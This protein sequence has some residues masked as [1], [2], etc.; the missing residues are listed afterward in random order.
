MNKITRQ[1]RDP[2]QIPHLAKFLTDHFVMKKF[3]LRITIERYTAR[4][5]LEQNAK[6]H[7]MVGDIAEHTGDSVA[8][9]KSD[10][11][12]YL[13]PE[14]ESKVTGK[15]RPK[16]THELSTPEFMD[17]IEATYA[18]GAQLNVEWSE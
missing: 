6:W 7:A 10:V 8:S 4:R 13:C 5:S 18:L 12:A 2:A 15:M 9:V 3:P 1:I 11:K 16:D 17:L 14:V